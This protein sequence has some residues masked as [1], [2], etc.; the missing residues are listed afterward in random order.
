MTTRDLLR[1]V[2][3]AVDKE[4]KFAIDTPRVALVKEAARAILSAG[5]EQQYSSF[6]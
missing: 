6:L 2:L 3:Q 5:Q 4:E 1:E